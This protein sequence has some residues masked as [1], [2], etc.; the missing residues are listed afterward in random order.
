MSNRNL[1]FL[2]IIAA[3]LLTWA[4]IQSKIS[5]R[6]RTVSHG[7]AYLVSGLN[8]EDLESIE[9]KSGDN[10][11]TIKR[12]GDKFVLA[13]KDNYPVDISKIND[14]ISKC[15]D[16][17]ISQIIT[18]KS[19]NHKDLG[20]VEE[21]AQTVIKFIKPDSSVLMGL[22]IGNTK[23]SGQGTYVRL[24]SNDHVYEAAEIPYFETQEI[25][26]LKKMIVSIVRKDIEKVT[27]ISPEGQ[28]T[29]EAQDGSNDIALANI[30][31]GKSL[32]KTDADSVFNV[33]SDLNFTDVMKDPG[34]L[35]FENT[36]I[37]RLFNTTEFTFNIAQKDEKTFIKCSAKF[38]EGRPISIKKDE[39]QEQ[40]K[41]K[42]EKLLLDD[43]ANDFT[44]R[45]EGWVYQIP[46]YKAG[47][48]TKA[49]A[50]LLEDQPESLE[51][52]DVNDI[53]DPNMILNNLL[54]EQ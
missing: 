5:N 22:I 10:A 27:V 43:K 53:T 45:H 37:C 4:V 46:D 38:T 30:P 42:E 52:I 12:S 6:T 47:N 29:L 9:I 18:D 2:V 28:Y 13:E 33:L 7:P 23:E 51:P 26:Y 16:I 36:Y 19:N 31:A 35:T 20:V 44:D 11:F 48:L 25:N 32:K 17:K 40:L 41:E 34:D 15:L 39:P 24:I 50:D 54:F 8:T 49:L 21:Y 14:L 3:V 1:V